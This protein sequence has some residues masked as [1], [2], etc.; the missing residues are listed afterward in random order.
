MAVDKSMVGKSGKPFTMPIE[1][2]KVREFARED[3]RKLAIVFDNPVAGTIS[4]EN[5]E[6][7]VRMEHRGLGRRARRVTA[8]AV[9]LAARRR[10]RPQPTRRVAAGRQVG[11][12]AT[13]TIKVRNQGH[14]PPLPPRCQIRAHRQNNRWLRRRQPTSRH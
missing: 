5:Y 12:P 8:R 6:D 2:S 11:E 7:A 10:Q 1:W 4:E 3:E 13:Y 14:P 9:A